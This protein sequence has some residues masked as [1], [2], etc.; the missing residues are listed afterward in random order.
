MLNQPL[1]DALTA[2]F[3]EVL[4]EHEGVQ[5]TILPDASGNGKWYISDDK[6]DESGEEYRVKCPFCRDHKKHLYISYLSYATP[7]INGET[8]RQGPLLAHCF[9]RNCL[10]KQENREWLAGR[11]GMAMAQEAGEGC[12]VAPVQ[13]QDEENDVQ[14]E[15][16]QLS[17][18]LTLEG[19]RTWVPDYE[20]IDEDTDPE[21]IEYLNERRI[22][23]DDVDWLHIGWGPVVSPRSGKVLNNGKPWVLFP[24]VNNG[25]LVGIQARCLPQYL[26]PKGI[27]YWFHPA[28]RKKALMYN[29]DEARR[30]G[31]AVVCEGVFD[32]ASVGRPG[33]A[34]FGHTP[35]VAQR[36]FLSAM[37]NGLIWLPDTDEHPDFDTVEMAR[38][39]VAD[40][41]ADSAFRYGAHVVVLPSKDAGDM[42]RQ[43]VWETIITQVPEE[44]RQYLMKSVIPKL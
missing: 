44:M 17:E 30:F 25:K 37:T 32:V 8:F 15:K 31:L 5:A 42:T 34:T 26:D 6:D 18:D 10:R 3:G 19:I 41:N 39:Q 38:G 40:F 13:Q 22:S 7:S 20:P 4:V 28:C 35:S 1:Y 33:V 9:R 12:M 11:I 27:K 29:L 2:L 16:P 14:D 36:R 23:Q 43:E 21:V 24:I